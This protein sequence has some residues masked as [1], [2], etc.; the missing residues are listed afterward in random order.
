MPEL[1]VSPVTFKI[2]ANAT[3]R[4]GVSASTGAQVILVPTGGPQGPPGPAFDG[5]AWW[6]GEGPPGTVIGSKAGDYYID[7]LTGI[8]YKLT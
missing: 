7:T 1:D 8:V 3:A 6:T 5:T 4:I 2:R